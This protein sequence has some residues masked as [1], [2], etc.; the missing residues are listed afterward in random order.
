MPTSDSTR[1]GERPIGP[2]TTGRGVRLETN[3]GIAT[4]S[5][6]LNALAHPRR[7]I[8]LYYLQTHQ[9]AT[10]DELARQI[11]A[12]E[13]EGS[14]DDVPADARERVM[15]ELVHIHLPQLADSLF[16]EYD[17]RSQMVMYTEPPALLETVL[18]VLAQF[19]REFGG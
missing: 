1:C 3:G 5:E 7:R 17:P 15:T 16:V 13:L 18:E 8:A 14:P 9:R 11:V 10:V 2:P 19:E 12:W 6:V 4:L